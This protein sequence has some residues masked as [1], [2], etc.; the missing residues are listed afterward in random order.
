MCTF[1]LFVLYKVLYHQPHQFSGTKYD[2]PKHI[3][4]QCVP[5]ELFVLYKV[6]HHQPN[7]SSSTKYDYPQYILIQSIV[8]LNTFRYNVY[9]VNCLS[10]TK[11]GTT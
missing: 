10:S 5:C 4:V 9:L 11:S 1:E 3:L 8:I 2:Y 7:P 6:L